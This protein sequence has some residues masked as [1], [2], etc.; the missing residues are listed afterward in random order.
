MK[1]VKPCGKTWLLIW[2][3]FPS[4]KESAVD[5]LYYF[6]GQKLA[7]SPGSSFHSASKY[8]GGIF[9]V[10][11]FSTPASSGLLLNLKSQKFPTGFEQTPWSRKS[12]QDEAKVCSIGDVQNFYEAKERRYK[13][14]DEWW[15]F[16]EVF[17]W[18]FGIT[19][20]FEIDKM[21]SGMS[22]PG[23][24][25]WMMISQIIRSCSGSMYPEQLASERQASIHGLTYAGPLNSTA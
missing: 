20:F 25:L 2:C 24:P 3:H 17:C 19:I 6:A 8:S 9:T 12:S 16:V 7:V 18:I 13:T 22:W 15:K 10:L 5:F 4:V 14:R 11:T 21:Q 23:H 1:A